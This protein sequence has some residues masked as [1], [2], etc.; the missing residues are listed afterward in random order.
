MFHPRV[1][2]WYM[3]MLPR[4]HGKVQ[5]ISLQE[6]ASVTAPNEGTNAQL[7]IIV[8]KAATHMVDPGVPSRPAVQT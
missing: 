4:S 8:S 2:S 7:P 1:Q 6:Q 3:V 5:T